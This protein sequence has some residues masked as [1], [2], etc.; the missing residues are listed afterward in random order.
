MSIEVKLYACL[1]IYVWN[2]YIAIGDNEKVRSRFYEKI[3]RIVYND[4]LPIYKREREREIEK[5]RG[6]KRIIKRERE[7]EREKIGGENKKIISSGKWKK[8][9]KKTNGSK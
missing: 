5:K 6:A 1:D 7:R 3:L 2:I 8:G 9:E 4:L